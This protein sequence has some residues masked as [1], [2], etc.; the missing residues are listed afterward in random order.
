MKT[1]AP[2]IIMLVMIG[3]SL[4]TNICKHG[5][6]RPKYNGPFSFLD[7]VL[8]VVVLYWGGFFG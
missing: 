8:A 2:Q 4:I 5:Q 6:D 3:F 7:C 1:G